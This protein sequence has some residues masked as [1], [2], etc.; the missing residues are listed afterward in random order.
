MDIYIVS[1]LHSLTPIHAQS[2]AGL[3]HGTSLA[4]LLFGQVLEAAEHAA[5]AAAHAGA[6]RRRR[7]GLRNLAGG[8]DDAAPVAGCG[9]SA[10]DLRWHAGLR[11]EVAGPAV[12]GACCAVDGFVVLFQHL[13][14]GCDAGED[15]GG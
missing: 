12:Q 5:E 4:V 13:L 7:R 9:V 14:E 6:Q 8:D 1:F 11:V 3:P 15:G 10:G 2:V